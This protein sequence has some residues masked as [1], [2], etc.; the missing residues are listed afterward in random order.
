VE[1]LTLFIVAKHRGEAANLL[2]GLA[3]P[4]QRRARAFADAVLA[5]DSAKRQARLTHEFGARPE[6]KERLQALLAQA[7]PRLRDA[8]VK[9]LPEAFKEQY[10]A[11]KEE[12]SPVAQG[13]LA[14]RLVREAA[15]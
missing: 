5:W 13:A 11:A 1:R 15:R 9:R 6:T 3:E 8:L 14:A 4:G 2:H 7:P 10:P 12:P